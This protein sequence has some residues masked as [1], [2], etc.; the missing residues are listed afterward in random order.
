[1]PRV[2]HNDPRRSEAEPVPPFWLCNGHGGPGQIDERVLAVAKDNWSWAF[3]LVRKQL[4]DC[5]RAPQIVE[6]VATEVSNRLTAEPEVGRNLNG[7]FRTAVI[8]RVKTL[9]ARDSRIAYEGGAQD[10][11]V[12]HQLT[13]PDWTKVFEDRMALQSLLPYMSQPVRLI[14]HY[15]LLDYPWKYIS[16]R[17]AL[18]EKQAKSRFYYGVHQAYDELLAVQERRVRGEESEQ[19]K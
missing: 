19:W 7:Y 14:L 18:T 10:L 16:E 4:R 1:M 3:W 9:A 12:N 8:R 2:G 17:L 11:E 15:R 13:A 5:E 6:E